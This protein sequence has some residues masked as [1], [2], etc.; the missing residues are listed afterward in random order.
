[1][2]VA[3]GASTRAELIRV[4]QSLL[5]GLPKLKQCIILDAEHSESQLSVR[6]LHVRDVLQDQTTT[7]PWFS[8]GMQG[9]NDR[10]RIGV[11]RRGEQ[12][13]EQ[14][15]IGAIGDVEEALEGE[16]WQSTASGLRLPTSLKSTNQGRSH[17]WVQHKHVSLPLR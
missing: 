9:A 13:G 10:A 6:M 16:P 12:S 2:R 15:I 7:F 8:V 3:T 11:R 5:D 17:Q 14:D 4:I 1:M